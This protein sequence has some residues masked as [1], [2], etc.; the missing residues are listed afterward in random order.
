MG[1]RRCVLVDAPPAAAAAGAAAE[2][3]DA[4]D[5]PPAS[6]EPERKARAP[7]RRRVVLVG[8]ALPASPASEAVDR[9]RPRRSDGG[10]G[11][12]I[13]GFSIP[14][15]LRAPELAEKRAADNAALDAA[16]AEPASPAPVRFLGFAKWAQRH[17]PPAEQDAAMHRA[18]RV[19]FGGAARACFWSEYHGGMLRGAPAT[20]ESDLAVCFAGAGG[21]GKGGPTS[22]L[23]VTAGGA[24]GGEADNPYAALGDRSAIAVAELGAGEAPPKKKPRKQGD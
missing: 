24:L 20:N 16:V 10:G 13:N 8:D 17:V 3:A 4:A 6:G 11:L 18:C 15:P 14:T 9:K 19:E 5:S 2:P 22:K 12:N 7:A 23:A 21:T 1:R